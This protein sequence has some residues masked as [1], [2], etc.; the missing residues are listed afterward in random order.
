M[1]T[2]HA[3]IIV[4]FDVLALPEVNLICL[5]DVGSSNL[6]TKL[7]ATHVSNTCLL[8]LQDVSVFL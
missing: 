5:V 4:L 2:R 7:D 6:T 3:Y 1:K 8:I